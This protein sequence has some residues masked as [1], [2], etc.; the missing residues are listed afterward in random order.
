MELIKNGILQRIFF[1]RDTETVAREL[2]GK[3][4]VKKSENGIISGVIVETEAY[5]PENDMSSHSYPGKTKRNA[6]MFSEGGILYVYTIYGIHQCINF[7]T[8]AEGKGAA[9]LIRAIEPLEGVDLMKINRKVTDPLKLCKG[10]ANLTKAFGFSLTDNYS[11][12]ISDQLYVMSGIKIG[13]EDIAKTHR[14]GI[15]KSIDL[16]LRFYKKESKFVS[17]KKNLLD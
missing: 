16:R 12:L 7:V 10:P 15:T 17:G 5:L 3:I 8:E 13:E 11:D 9:V 4:L 6:P 2:I 14:I 1:L